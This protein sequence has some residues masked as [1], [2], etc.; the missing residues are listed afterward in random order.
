VAGSVGGGEDM[1][2]V[3]MSQLMHDDSFLVSPGVARAGADDSAAFD[4]IDYEMGGGGGDEYDDMEQ[5]QQQQQKDEHQQEDEPPSELEQDMSLLGDIEV[6]IAGLE[7]A[8]LDAD[9]DADMRAMADADDDATSPM[10]HQ[11]QKQQRTKKRKRA[12]ASTEQPDQLTEI[13]GKL[14][15]SSLR[16]AS[17]IRHDKN[18]T[19]VPST[20][21]A[22]V[23]H[24]LTTADASSRLAPRA[25]TADALS[26]TARWANL[27][28]GRSGALARFMI[29][30]A[31]RDFFNRN[32]TSLLAPEG[33]KEKAAVAAE[34][35]HVEEEGDEE[36][37]GDVD[38]DN[39]V[40]DDVNWDDSN[41]DMNVQYE[42][43]DDAMMMMADDEQ[44]QEQQPDEELQDAAAEE[45]EQDE[46]DAAAALHNA[47][48]A[49]PRSEL[50][51]QEQADVKT[52]V[53]ERTKKMRHVV[54]QALKQ[55]A[56]VNKKKNKKS[57]AKSAVVAFQELSQLEDRKTAAIAF[58]ELLVLKTRDE[59]HV[60]QHEAFANI[61]LSASDAL[62]V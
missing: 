18:R 23:L 17:D 54:V 2:P 10:A 50:F 12:A 55:Q 29:A 37:Q 62:V 21:R 27:L 40:V 26:E 39:L 31:L 28:N 49:L 46:E 36:Q 7:N 20:K 56:A 22:R 32:A 42:E 9:L 13:P 58:Y 47:S 44:Q 43:P 34:E 53:T 38:L 25:A 41:V 4:N 51:D 11:L 3:D 8:N 6:N 61:M 19:F 60:E 33:A 52:G 35:A 5:Q 59:I 14:I 57:T 30:P 24:D 16:D 15:K 48:A 45:E 1:L